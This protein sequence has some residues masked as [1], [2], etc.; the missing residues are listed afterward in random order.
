M[1]AWSLAQALAAKTIPDDNGYEAQER[2]RFDKDFAAVE[3]VRVTV[4]EVGVGEDA[5]QKEQ[6]CRRKNEIVQASP[7]RTADTGAEQRREEHDQKEI[8]SCGTGEVEFWLKRGLDGQED[9]EQAEAGFI[10]E[11]KDGRMRQRECDSNVGGPL[12][13]CEE[14]QV[15]MRPESYRAVAQRDKHAKPK[16]DGSCTDRSQ[17]Q[18]GAQVEDTDWQAQVDS[19]V[20][21]IDSKICSVE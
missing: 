13:E 21:W 5:V 1:F 6:H 12:V 2:C 15:S 9:V 20:A 4:P 10:E 18:I 16:I 19:M 17:T 3:Q 14:I 7:E 8:E 11:E